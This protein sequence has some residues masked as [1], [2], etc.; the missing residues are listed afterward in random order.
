[1]PPR[2]KIEPDQDDLLESS[3][4]T[5][6]ILEKLKI[7]KLTEDIRRVRLQNGLASGTLCDRRLV[8][9]IVRP[10]LV[11]LIEILSTM[12]DDLTTDLTMSDGA[13]VYAKL[14][15]WSAH[16][17]ESLLERLNGAT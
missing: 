4:P 13:V 16:K 1:M 12:A 11:Q 6:P 15:E 10:T 14:N 2:K 9:E 17:M 7:E 5:G 8:L 3:G